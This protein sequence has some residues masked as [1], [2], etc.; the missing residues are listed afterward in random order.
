MVK[1]EELGGMNT[2]R[3]GTCA[4]HGYIK[5]WWGCWDVDGRKSADMLL[6]RIL[7]VLMRPF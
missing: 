5:I 3:L 2:V 1:E 6:P 7:A 4:L